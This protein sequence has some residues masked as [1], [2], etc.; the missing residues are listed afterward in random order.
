MPPLDRQLGEERQTL[1][2]WNEYKRLILHELE[3]LNTA[4]ELLIRKIDETDAVAYDAAKGV[5]QLLNEIAELKKIGNDLTNQVE[6]NT[7]VLFGIKAAATAWG[8]AAG[9]FF[10]IVG[11]ALQHFT[12]K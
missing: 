8:A 4:I 1:N 11:L 12:G 5:T 9:L 3:R 2:G 7:R 6:Q 10:A